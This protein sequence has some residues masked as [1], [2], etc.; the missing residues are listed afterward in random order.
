MSV[1]LSEYTL[2]DVWTPIRASIRT[3]ISS[4][5]NEITGE[6]LESADATRIEALLYNYTHV[7]R[8]CRMS[9][10]TEHTLETLQNLLK[11][12]FTHQIYALVSEY[13]GIK[14]YL[15]TNKGKLHIQE[16]F[17]DVVDAPRIDRTEF[18][19]LD[20]KTKQLEAMYTHTR[21]ISNFYN[22]IKLLVVTIY[23]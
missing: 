17:Y 16:S 14:E 10:D 20:I 12:V 15:D 2:D 8:R 19:D 18:N 4:S 6:T 9:F 1:K 13:K 5:Y 7:L 23:Y 11:D 3:L 21:A 22:E